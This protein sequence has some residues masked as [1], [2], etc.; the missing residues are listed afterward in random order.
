MDN[1][2]NPQESEPKVQPQDIAS[3][4]LPAKKKS[5]EEFSLQWYMKMLAIIYVLLGILYIIL[6]LTLK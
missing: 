2:L 1:T 6:K 5:A 4:Q 3:E